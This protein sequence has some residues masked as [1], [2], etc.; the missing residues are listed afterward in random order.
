[1]FIEKIKNFLSQC[2]RV[3]L[4][5]TKPGKDEYKLSVKI[6]GLGILIIGI[7]GFIIFLITTAIGGL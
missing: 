7:V 2:K 4:V 1:M 3:F 6:T 5:S